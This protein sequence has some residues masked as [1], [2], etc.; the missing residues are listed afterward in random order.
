MFLFIIDRYIAISFLFDYKPP[1]GGLP[2]LR[3]GSYRRSAARN[4]RCAAVSFWGRVTVVGAGTDRGVSGGHS[5]P[6]GVRLRRVGRHDRAVS[7]RS[8]QSPAVAS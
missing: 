1:A 2:R 7:H 3:L 8:G 4:G 5:R 6:S